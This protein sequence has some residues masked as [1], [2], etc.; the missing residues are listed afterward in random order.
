M[1][2]ANFRVLISAGLFSIALAA[3]IFLLWRNQARSNYGAIYNNGKTELILYVGETCPHCKIAEKYI[4]DNNLEEKIPLIE[5][6]VYNNNANSQELT[7]KAKFC[8][9][10]DDKIGVP[11]L[12][13]YSKADGVNC[14][15]GDQEIINFFETQKEFYQNWK[16]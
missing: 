11:F 6:E 10:Q 15:I 13:F 4:A 9:I 16:Q 7:Q 5:K 8:N 3:G 12:W 14:L 1:E 2:K